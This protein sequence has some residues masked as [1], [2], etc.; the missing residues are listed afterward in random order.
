MTKPRT[1]GRRPKDTSLSQDAI[2]RAAI[3]VLD[4]AGD[5]GLTFRVLA[6][7]LKTGAGTL[8]WHVA[9]REE[10][11]DLAS[12][13][14][15]DEVTAF[16]ASQGSDPYTVIR[17]VALALYDTLDR[18][19]WVGAHLPSRPDLP[20]ALRILDCLGQQLVALQVAR[21]RQFYVATA[22]FIYVIGVAAQ[23]SRNAKAAAAGQSRDDHLAKQATR[24]AQL[25]SAAYPFLHGHAAELRE[26]ED[27][28]QF[29]TGLNLLLSGIRTSLPV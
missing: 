29:L 5:A 25:D 23:E 10:L 13:R 7:R 3:E 1:P 19:P 6:E 4:E 11:L 9:S 17:E 22:I 14:V 2:I 20:G 27:R 18:H 21:E 15:L 28:E 16:L 24:W 26:H 8:Y 12:D